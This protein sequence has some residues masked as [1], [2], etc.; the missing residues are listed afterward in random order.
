M[1]RNR[2]IGQGWC[3]AVTICLQFSETDYKFRILCK[4]SWASRNCSQYK[5]FPKVGNHFRF[6]WTNF[7][8]YKWFPKVG[9]HCRFW[10]KLLF[11]LSQGGYMCCDKCG[12]R[13][14][15]FKK[16]S[17]L[18][19]CQIPIMSV[20]WILYYFLRGRSPSYIYRN[21]GGSRRCDVTAECKMNNPK[22]L[23]TKYVVSHF[24][25]VA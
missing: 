21:L 12:A 1:S 16:G 7:S 24:E 10:W 4:R 3:I 18:W 6:W 11:L 13:C 17:L 15:F 20:T 23:E 25:V 22:N 5:W 9:N 19:N 2:A 8:Q 14:S